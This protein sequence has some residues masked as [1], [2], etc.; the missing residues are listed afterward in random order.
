[1]N[2]EKNG[3]TRLIAEGQLQKILGNHGSLYIL[4][5]KAPALKLALIV[6]GNTK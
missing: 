3:G 5:V 4:F 6:E 2:D 1:M